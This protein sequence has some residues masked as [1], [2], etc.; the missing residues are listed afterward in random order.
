M[1]ARMG[2]RAQSG[3]EAIGLGQLA[4]DRGL[5]L[6]GELLGQH[7]AAQIGVFS[8]N[9][10][11]F[12]GQFPAGEAPSLFRQFANRV[13][14]HGEVGYASAPQPKLL[15]QL[16]RATEMHHQP[17]LVTYV[18]QL[19]A[20]AL[21]LPPSLIDVQQLLNNMGLDSLMAFELRNRLKTDLGVD[22]PV[23]KFLAGISVADLAALLHGQLSD[24][25][26][27]PMPAPGAEEVQIA[28]GFMGEQEAHL[29]QA[30]VHDSDWI[31]GEI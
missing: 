8:V 13:R 14:H 5:Q 20:N 11:R 24:I 28:E 30:R 29:S 25:S 3:M 9:W 19:V 6:L 21:G 22:L 10:D 31:E 7:D 15:R 27:S 16:D 2:S 12:I 26:P 18:Q 23:V 4:P 17:Q 1:M